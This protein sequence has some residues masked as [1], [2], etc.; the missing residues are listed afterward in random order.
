MMR[1][2]A[3]WALKEMLKKDLRRGKPV[4]VD[5]QREGAKGL[6]VLAVVVVQGGEEEHEH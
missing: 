6:R 1:K 5:E 2:A 4:S 3:Q